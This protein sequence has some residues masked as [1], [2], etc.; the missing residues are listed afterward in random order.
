VSFIV[1]YRNQRDIPYDLSWDYHKLITKSD[2][3]TSELDHK[4]V[5][6]HIIS[7]YHILRLS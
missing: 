5:L 7:H 3:R 6:R 2:L 1:I 4:F